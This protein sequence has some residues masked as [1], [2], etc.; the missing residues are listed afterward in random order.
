MLR[1]DVRGLEARKSVTENIVDR[2]EKRP[3][4]DRR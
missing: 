3:C 4:V 1:A 2:R